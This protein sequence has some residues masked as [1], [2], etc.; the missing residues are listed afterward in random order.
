LVAFFES[1]RIHHCRWQPYRQTVTPFRY[2]RLGLLDIHGN[3]ISY[4]EPAQRKA[5]A[6]DPF[7]TFT[8]QCSHDLGSV[9]FARG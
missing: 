6:G 1:E 9:P 2:L 8:F 3:C 4:G 5:F 7:A